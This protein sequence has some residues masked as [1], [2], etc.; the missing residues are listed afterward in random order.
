LS[1]IFAKELKS[2]LCLYVDD[3]LTFH[4]DVD[5][6][7]DFLAILFQKFREFNIRVHAC[8]LHLATSSTSYL[9]FSLDQNGYGIDQ[10]RCKIVKNFP[11]HNTVKEVKRYLGCAS[12]LGKQSKTTAIDRHR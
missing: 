7:L 6:H 11:R 2:N 10:T 9:G 5:T 1:R 3:L 4:H 12:I 8:K